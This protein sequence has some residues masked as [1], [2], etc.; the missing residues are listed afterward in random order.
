M[1]WSTAF[2]I[3]EGVRG[4]LWVGHINPWAGLRVGVIGDLTK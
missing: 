1:T 4:S 2:R 3:R